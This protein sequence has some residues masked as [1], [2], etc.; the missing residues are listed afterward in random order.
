MA[1]IRKRIPEKLR[2]KLQ[3]EIGSECPIC[4]DQDIGHFEVH[5]LDE[6]P[7]NNA[8]SNLLMLCSMCHSNITKGDISLDEAKAF[9]KMLVIRSEKVRTKSIAI[10]GD[11]TNSAIANNIENLVIRTAKKLKVEPHKDSIGACLQRKNYVKH[12][13]D[14]YNQYKEYEVGKGN[15]KYAVIHSIIKKEFKASAYQLPVSQFEELC[16]FLQRRIDGTK[17]GKINRSKGRRN[18]SLYEG[19]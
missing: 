13:I 18:F 14:R 11:V 2:A 1:K 4:R 6:N 19:S 5:H 12:L 10:S 8:F 3:Q 16:I 17:L 9:K 7:E 15:V